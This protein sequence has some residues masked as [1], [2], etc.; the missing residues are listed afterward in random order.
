M[1]EINLLYRQNSYDSSICSDVGKCFR[2]RLSWTWSLIRINS[3]IISAE[4]DLS[5]SADR[6]CH[7]PAGSAWW[8]CTA[9]ETTTTRSWCETLS[10]STENHHHGGDIWG[11]LKD[12]LLRPEASSFFTKL[13]LEFCQITEKVLIFFFF[14]F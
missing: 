8:F 14:I 4:L 3:C 7:P 13:N 6:C 10:Q 12:V 2:V 1:F 5:V 11:L 9:T